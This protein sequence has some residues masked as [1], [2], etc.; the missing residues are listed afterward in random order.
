MTHYV[1][2]ND[3]NGDILGISPNKID[4][5]AGYKFTKIAN[6]IVKPFLEFKESH[7][8]WSVDLSDTSKL[9]KKENVVPFFHYEAQKFYDIATV[10]SPRPSIT[11][12]LLMKNNN[13]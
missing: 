5:L 6:E 12:T 10:D 4:E 3:T 13:C 11:V 7:V 2:Y 8:K 9:V 1:Y